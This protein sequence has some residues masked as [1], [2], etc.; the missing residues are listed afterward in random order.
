MDINVAYLRENSY[1]NK[2]E[3]RQQTKTHFP[4]DSYL[5]RFRADQ[6]D[7]LKFLP[8]VG[9]SKFPLNGNRG[10]YGWTYRNSGKINVRE[11]L[12]GEKKTE[13]LVH[14]AIHTP[15]EYETRRLTEWI[16]ES[17]QRTENKYQKRKE[18]LV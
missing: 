12:E 18:Y 7:L 14:E 5:D 10:L 9:V 2:S 8:F 3:K 11:D 1:E 13:V 4:V 15:D 17:M 16:I 6:K